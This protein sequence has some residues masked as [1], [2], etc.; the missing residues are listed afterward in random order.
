MTCESSIIDHIPSCHGAK[1]K[2]W[3]RDVTCK[4]AETLRNQHIWREHRDDGVWK[5]SMP[6]LDG[7]E[8]RRGAGGHHVKAATRRFTM[9]S[10]TLIRVSIYKTN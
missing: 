8:Q 5:H 9:A 4:R 1:W 10:Y 6:V 2:T 7:Q 3:L